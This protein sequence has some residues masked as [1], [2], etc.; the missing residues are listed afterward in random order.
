MAGS[1]TPLVD[2]LKSDIAAVSLMDPENSTI[3]DPLDNSVKTTIQKKK[4]AKAKEKADE[5]REAREAREQQ[6]KAYLDEIK[7]K[8]QVKVK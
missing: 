8:Y 1:P 5:E 2:P 4:D 3:T 7:R 6:A